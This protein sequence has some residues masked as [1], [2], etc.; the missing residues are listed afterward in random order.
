[1]QGSVCPEF[2]DLSKKGKAAF[3]NTKYTMIEA[4]E[5]CPLTYEY[6]H[7]LVFGGNLTHTHIYTHTHTHLHTL[8]HTYTHLHALRVSVCVCACVRMCVC[9]CVCDWR[10]Q[11]LIHTYILTFILTLALTLTLPLTQAMAMATLMNPSS[12][13]SK[14]LTVKLW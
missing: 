3:K 4:R 14:E 8:T 11:T 12:R 7:D 5:T 1:M 13:T 2:S 6:V 10:E 9:V